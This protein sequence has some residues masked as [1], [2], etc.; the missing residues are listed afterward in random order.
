MAVQGFGNVGGWA[1]RFLARAG[2]RVVAVSDINGVAYC[3]SGFSEQELK[4]A[5]ITDLAQSH[6]SIGSQDL[7]ELPVDI[8]V[9]AAAGHVLTGRNTGG[10]KAKLVIEA[11]NE[12]ITDDGDAVLEA[13]GVTVVPDILANAGGVV[14]SYAEWRQAKSGEVMER[15]QTYAII[16]DRLNRA[17]DTVRQARQ[18]LGV[19][20]RM[21]SHVI[22]VNE[23][24]QAM[25]ERKWISPESVRAKTALV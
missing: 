11:A 10:I 16:E 5:T 8:L 15:E 2:A 4:V 12:P 17:Y 22:A 9:P 7:F 23:V 1:A 24:V 19:S 21:A 14:T 6:S 3:E 20:C 13:A 18:E 25:I